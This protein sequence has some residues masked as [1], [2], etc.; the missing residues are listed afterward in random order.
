MESIEIGAKNKNLHQNSRLLTSITSLFFWRLP[1][2]YVSNDFSLK[3]RVYFFFL[4]FQ[5]TEKN[6]QPEKKKNGQKN[7]RKKTGESTK[8]KPSRKLEHCGLLS[9]EGKGRAFQNANIGTAFWLMP[10]SPTAPGILLC[11]INIKWMDGCVWS[12]KLQNAIFQ[13]S[14]SNLTPYTHYISWSLIT[15]KS[16]TGFRP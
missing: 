4:H 12:S 11:I 14:P 6:K 15:L 13:F 3:L 10:L 1:C 9:S 2:P 7:G 5:N 16:K 8:W